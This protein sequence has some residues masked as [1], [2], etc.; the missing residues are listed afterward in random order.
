[1]GIIQKDAVRITILSYLGLILGYLNKGVLFIIFLN[2]D[3]V[4]L[5]GLLVS[6][7]LL[8]AQFS[9]LGMA[10]SVWKFF[11]FFRNREKGNYGFFQLSMLITLIGIAIFTLLS[12]VLK[13]FVCSFYIE[14]SASFI[15]Y[16][17]WIL[18]IG[19]ATSLFFTL[20]NFLRAIHK[21]I[22]SIL[23]TELILRLAV[24]FSVLLYAAGW[25]DFFL[26]VVLQC[27]SYILPTLI[28]ALQLFKNRE[29]HWK[30]SGIAIPR[31][32]RRILFSYS[33]Y[34]YVNYIGILFVVSLDTV[35]VASMLGLEETGVFSTII[36]IASTLQVPYKSLIRVSSPFV[37]VYWKERD[38]KSMQDMY[39]R[40]SSIGLVIGLFIFLV[41]WTSRTEIFYFLPAS[42]A[43]GIP[44]FLLLMIARVTDMYCG[45]NSIIFV[46]SKKYKYDVIF[47][48]SLLG[49]VVAMN[50]WL[51][52]LYGITGAAL[53][54]TLMYI[55]Y[56]LGRLLFVYI[57]YGLHPFK[58]RQ[59]Q[60]IGLF[61]A[62]LFAFE[63]LPVMGNALVSAM[64]KTAL[65]FGAFLLPIYWLK[66]DADVV[67]YM[68]N[69]RAMVPKRK[70]KGSGSNLPEAGD[71]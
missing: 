40:V 11:P 47:M 13:D 41:F 15:H 70:R 22:V 28:L 45:L 37:S 63:L 57:A 33:V 62:V 34:S 6:V 38:M 32:F 14:K 7:G 67:S 4:G 42:F 27:T 8:F 31:K 68:L 71:D 10:Y 23:S 12:V 61:V 9:N 5:L 26:L 19:I 29:L 30:L 51:I 35:M 60:V 21:N 39:V 58:W 20:D 55:L 17:Y 56:N 25:I 69:I 53:S 46:T 66:L 43:H 52:P 50:L 64:M 1:M 3:Q 65:V 18:P 59:V 48:L 16:Y 2:M 49:M 54:T 24:T 44:A 36:Y